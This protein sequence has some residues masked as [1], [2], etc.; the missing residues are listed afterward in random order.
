M[1]KKKS[2]LTDLQDQIDY[3]AK[4]NKAQNNRIIFLE[5]W[6]IAEHP[7]AKLPTGS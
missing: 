5:Q 4:E 2:T 1:A 7:E 6:Y 3:L